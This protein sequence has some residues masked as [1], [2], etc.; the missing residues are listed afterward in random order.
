VSKAW[1]ES[2]RL[3]HWWGP[4][5]FTWVSGKK[6]LQVGG[7]FH[8]GMRSPD[9][10]EMWGKFVYREITAPTRLIFTNSFTDAKGNTIRAQFSATWPLEVLNTLTFTEQEGNT[11]LT[12]RGIPFNATETGRK[13]FRD[14]QKGMQQGFK[15]TLDQLDDYLAKVKV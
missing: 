3:K 15:G 8:Y 5:G 6:D 9:G 4:K 13:T 2:E 1:N 11:M 10:Q 12:L 14:A 7:V